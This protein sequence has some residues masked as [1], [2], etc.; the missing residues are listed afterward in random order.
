[1]ALFQGMLNNLK[2]V[3][4][5]Q[6]EKD[7]GQYLTDGETIYTGFKLVRDTLII[8]DIRIIDFDKQGATGKKMRVESIY[9][10]SI[11]RVS[12]E[13]AGF[14]FDDSELE[15]TYVISPYRKAHSI[16]M[17]S[18]K[19]EFPKKFDVASLYVQLEKI[20]YDNLQILNYGT[21]SE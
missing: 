7:Y 17:V 12:C 20:A 1:M 6:L 19:Y 11:V 5:E 16:Q 10:D 21:T 13:T 18:K 8:T 4:T 2:E 9:L 3:S 15:I 14:G